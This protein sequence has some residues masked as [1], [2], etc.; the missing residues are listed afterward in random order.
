MKKQEKKSAKEM[1]ETMNSPCP[2]EGPCDCLFPS[3]EQ[4]PDSA[5]LSPSERALSLSLSL[6]ARRIPTNR[7]PPPAATAAA[8]RAQVFV[9]PFSGN[10]HPTNRWYVRPLLFPF[11]LGTPFSSLPAPFSSLHAVRNREAPEA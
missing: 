2:G 6:S 5:I 1:F 9:G 4:P 11:F 10:D 7:L 3:A 8:R